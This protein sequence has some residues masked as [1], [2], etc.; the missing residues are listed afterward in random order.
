[1]IWLASFPRSGNTFFRNVLYEVYGLASSTYHQDEQRELD[2]NFASFPVVKTHLLP[3][4]LPAEWRDKPSVYLIRDGRDALVSIAHH[5]K[6]IVAP[7]T[8]FFNNLLEAILAQKGSFFGGWS[9]NVRQWTQKAD[10]V[11]RFQDLIQDPIREIEKLRSI[12]DLPQPNLD[13]LPTFKDLKFGQP[14]YGGG[15]GKQF[16]SSRAQKHFRKGRVGEW[17]EELPANLEK[18][19]WAQHGRTLTEWGYEGPQQDLGNASPKRVMIEASKLYG[20]DND[21]IKR[22]LAELINGLRILTRYQAEW[23]ICLYDQNGIQSLRDLDSPEEALPSSSGADFRTLDEKEAILLDRRTMDYEK[24]LLLLK[25]FVKRQLPDALYDKLSVYYRQGPF[26]QLLT[27]VRQQAKS[28]GPRAESKDI[29]QALGQ[30]DLIHIPLPQHLS[31]KLPTDNLLLVS[32]HD[33]THHFFPDYHTKQNIALA[34]NGMQQ[35]VQRQ[36]EVLAVSQS[37][38][39]DV[40]AHYPIPTARIHLCYE[41]AN[42]GR[43][44]PSKRQADIAP[45]REKYGL[46][47]QPYLMCLST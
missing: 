11:I 31:P 5:R 12:I 44:N 26:R 29:A 13:K 45:L 33:L 6:D 41:A 28:W 2:P 34:E 20:Q 19:L 43:F 14:Q 9:K 15:R 46:P 39:K 32:V 8:D 17:K 3:A 7:G 24:K 30:A 1:M 36:A 18:V 38:Q 25:A 22:Y 47:S 27:K 23:D 4:D 16:L 40:L 35:I 10:I 42:M 37:T 21:G